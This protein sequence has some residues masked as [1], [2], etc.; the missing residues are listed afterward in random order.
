MPDTDQ[1]ARQRWYAVTDDMSALPSWCVMN[2]AK[3]PVAAD[4]A[5]GE[6]QI[7]RYLSEYDARVI[8]DNHNAGLAG[9]PA[10]RPVRYRVNDEDV[11]VFDDLGATITRAEELLKSA[12]DTPSYQ[13]STEIAHV[14]GVLHQVV[15]ALNLL[16][17]GAIRLRSQDYTGEAP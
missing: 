5:T 10:E 8:A 14:K 12:D 17:E 2:V 11:P 16:T 1:I 4:P 6:Y 7:A 9:K 3:T 15:H 13:P